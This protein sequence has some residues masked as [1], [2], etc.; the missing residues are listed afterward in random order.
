M[1]KVEQGSILRDLK[2]GSERKKNKFENLEKC[3]EK[4]LEH[5][6]FLKFH[7]YFPKYRQKSYNFFRNFSKWF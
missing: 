6:I 5:E 7:N 4:L 1:D 3:S 2:Y